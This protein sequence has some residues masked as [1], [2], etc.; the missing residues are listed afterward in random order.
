MNTAMAFE[1]S[2]KTV[3]IGGASGFWG[4]SVLGATQLVRSGLIDYLVF[5][6]LA[7]TTMAILAA[8]RS[9]KPEMGYATDFVDMAMKAV[10]PEVMQRGIKVVANAG[11]MNP[12]GCADALQA[13]AHSMGLS[14]KIAVVLGDDISALLPALR[15]ADTRD[16]NRGEP[17]P[18]K[19]L[20]ANAYLG[21]LPVARALAEGA[22]IVI[23]G[24][25][26]DSAVTLGPLMHEFGWSATDYGLLAGGSLAGHI[27]ECGCQAT[28]GLHTDWQDVPDW[29]NIGYPIIDCFADGSFELH[30]APGTGGKILRAAVAEQL[31]YEIGDPGAYLLPDV[32]CDFRS[33]KIEQLSAERVRVSGAVGHAPSAQYKVSAT[34]MDGYRCTGTL[35]IIGIDAA[36]KARRTGEAILSRTRSMLQQ[37]GLPDFSRATVELLGAETIYGPHARVGGA[38]EVMVRVIV[39]HPLKPALELFAKEI[40]PAGT[41][42]SPGTT[43]PGGGRPTPSPHIKPFSFLVDKASV[44]VTVQMGGQIWRVTATA[45]VASTAI[46]SAPHAPALAEPAAWVESGEA[47]TE[48]PLIHLAW[49][50]SGDKGDI[51]N[52]GLV[53]RRA[54]WLP[55]LWARVTPEVVKAYFAHLVHGRVERFH[56]P[57]IAAM[58]LVMHEALDGGGPA[59]TRNDPLGKAMGQMLLDMPVRVPVSIAQQCATSNCV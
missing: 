59:S 16:L 19:V 52:I 45:S 50:R 30:K 44:A 47:E 11:G 26:V 42:W 48:V 27:I 18:A 34:A 39:S 5:D 56:L 1:N 17:L 10:L 3:R 36:A 25:G 9:K 49:A 58:N 38:R 53:A 13:L 14:P 6:Y 12:Q 32:H 29:P 31:L 33:V 7:E 24:R 4:D 15:E 20:S 40:S 8:V 22:D 51:A 41:S 2:R 57:G 43:G 54:E 35:L 37:Q 55:L 28:G 46:A 23:T 21:A